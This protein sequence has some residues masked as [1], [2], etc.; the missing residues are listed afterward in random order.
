MRFAINVIGLGFGDEGKGATVDK[1]CRDTSADLVVRYS[2]GAQCGHTVSGN[3]KKHVFSQFGSGTLRGVLTYLGPDVIV[4]PHALFNEAVSLTDVHN[5]ARPLSLLLIHPDCVVTTPYTRLLNQAREL[6]R[7]SHRGRHGSCG[8]GIGE[9]RDLSRR[10]PGL[11]VHMRML[12]CPRMLERALRAQQEY[13]ASTMRE[14]FGTDNIYLDA[15]TNGEALLQYCDDMRRAAPYLVFRSHPPTCNIAVF[16]GAQGVLLDENYGGAPHHTWSSVM[17][18]EALRL[19]PI[20]MDI[21]RVRTIGV[22]RAF[23]TRHGRGPL[24]TE[25]DETEVGNLHDPNNPP[26]Q[27][28]G[29]FR[30]GWL[31]IPLLRYAVAACA[32][33]GCPIDGLAVNHVDLISEVKDFAIGVEYATEDAQPLALL[34]GTRFNDTVPRSWPGQPAYCEMLTDMLDTADP[35]FEDFSEHARGRDATQF[36][37][38]ALSDAGLPE[39]Y[40]LGH[41]PTVEQRMWTEHGNDEIVRRADSLL[42]R[43]SLLGAPAYSGG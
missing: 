4:D 12:T 18:G 29:P 21:G 15:V 7:Q 32:H 30:W 38:D 31:D 2:G 19:L 40:L 24:P 39:P 5:I 28:Q 9:A 8:R 10:M 36:L 25:L 6:T 3:G 22:T 35:G 13:A 17:P 41:G 23:T 11:T 26:S 43:G 37:L 20:G 33:S 27:W 42:N 16:E 1:I 14:L 34:H